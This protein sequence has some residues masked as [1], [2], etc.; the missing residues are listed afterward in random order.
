MPLMPLEST[1]GSEVI[2]RNSVQGS[3]PRCT[4]GKNGGLTGNNGGLS[5]EMEDA[6]NLPPTEGLSALVVLTVSGFPRTRAVSSEMLMLNLRQGWVPAGGAVIPIDGLGG[7][8]V[9]CLL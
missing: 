9:N 2:G 4:M 7:G 3:V 8:S 5:T 1:N 6:A